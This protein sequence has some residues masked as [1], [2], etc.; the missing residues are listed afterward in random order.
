MNSTKTLKLF[1]LFLLLNF[2]N[3][4]LSQETNVQILPK[5]IPN[6]PNASSLGKYG[7]IPVNLSTG[8]INYNIPLLEIEEGN[9]K[10][11]ISLNYNYSGLIVDEDPGIAGYGWNLTNNF[12]ITR[13][14]KGRPDD[15]PLGYFGNNFGNVYVKPYFNNILPF[16]NECDLTFASAKGRWDSE[17][18]LFIINTP[19]FSTSFF[20]NT[21]KEPIFLK[22]ENYK[23][24][25]IGN[26]FFNGFV[27]ID[28]N[29]NEYVFDLLETST[30]SPGFDGEMSNYT[31]AWHL[32]KLTLFNTKQPITFEYGGVPYQKET[33]TDIIKRPD[34]KTMTGYCN[35]TG[36]LGM[37]PHDESYTQT[38]EIDIDV[39][40]LAKIVFSKGEILFDNDVDNFVIKS[41]QLNDKKG[42]LIEKYNFNFYKVNNIIGKFINSIDK[43]NK[44]TDLYQRMYSFEYYNPFV[45]KFNYKMQDYWGYY[46]GISTASLADISENR[47]SGFNTS[48]YGA[49]KKITYP[50]TGY[51]TIEYEP[52]IIAVGT[53]FDFPGNYI[54]NTQ[55]YYSLDASRDGDTATLNQSLNLKGIVKVEANASASGNNYIQQAD[56]SF[57]HTALYNS[58]LNNDCNVN[59]N[60]VV[61]SASDYNE[62]SFINQP[63]VSKSCYFNLGEA[64]ANINLS[65][66]RS[67][68]S[69]IA[70]ASIKI[71]S[72]PDLL[73]GGIRV[74]KT[75]ECS[76]SGNCIS[77]EYKYINEQGLSSGFLLD[78]PL[79]TY[80]TTWRYQYGG[81]T[82]CD[83][84]IRNT[85]SSSKIPL[86]SFQGS[87]V[88][89]NRVETLINDGTNGKT[90]SYYD[91]KKN[92][93]NNK[94]G[95][96]NNNKDWRKG[97]LI[98]QEYYKF[99]NGSFILDNSIENTFEVYKPFTQQEALINNKIGMSFKGYFKNEI[100]RQANIPVENCNKVN[101]NNNCYQDDEL[102]EPEFYL[103]TKTIKKN[104]KVF[105]VVTEE[106]RYDYNKLTGK[107][108]NEKSSTSTEET[109]ETKYAYPQDLQNEP[110]ANALIAKNMIG[111]PL[112]TET[113]RN[114][115][116]LSEQKTE[117]ANDASTSNLLLPKYIYAKKGTGDI[118]KITDKKITYDQYDDKGNIL[119]YTPESGSPVALI[120]GYN[121]TQPIAK[122][123]N[124]T[125]A[126]AIAK[127]TTDENI[128][129][130]NLPKA[131]VT[132]YTYIPL[133]GVKSITDPK[134]QT[135]TYEY[136][137]FNRLKF[138]KDQDLNILQRYCYN[139]KGQI[140]DCS[141]V[142]QITYISS[143]KIGSFIKNNCATGG[144]G[145]PLT[146][147]EAAG[148]YSSTISQADADSKGLMKFNTDGQTYANTNGTCTFTSSTQSGLF[149]KNNCVT[150][151]VGSSV[152]YNVVAGAYTSTI[153]QVD[154]DA[155][156]QANV[157][158]NGQT[159]A[160]ANGT[161]TFK[162]IVKSGSFKSKNCATNEIALPVTYTVAAGTYTSIISQADADAKAQADVTVNGPTYADDVGKCKPKP[163]GIQK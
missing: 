95:I 38:T 70:K 115:E 129:R 21:N 158:A 134:G 155:K 6:S 91:G 92:F 20:L 1:C 60:L 82:P 120:W 67:Q 154:A 57:V 27:L 43:Y 102:Y 2:Q 72:N 58:C 74:K 112:K 128:F 87:P 132:T 97:N 40:V 118:S 139:Y 143:A 18:D 141:Q 47:K 42:D 86:I 19:T 31:S 65:V 113:F 109:L 76:E 127:Y 25:I 24:E 46:N 7:D 71:L 30:I 79:F 150:G 29:G 149:I 4:I 145:L 34:I 78:K 122:I 110:F 10:I 64:T 28:D 114:T 105:G 80:D 66:E 136:D 125:Y 96:Y 5:I 117:Y 147:S 22:G 69:G 32:R 137:Q 157:T 119:Q 163:G 104:N 85:L 81:N 161:C 45:G 59:N 152:T 41:I 50:T 61:I 75:I 133:V 15:G 8:K 37:I 89:Y 146:Y 63:S 17:P 33:H 121:Q 56:A 11:P 48:L 35:T 90:V 100:A 88:L 151:S 159:Y 39:R 130:N 99:L 68:N 153:S 116:K 51:T 14:V 12:S 3:S 49:L 101:L 77:K 126:E 162:S 52:Q 94:T 13:I 98:K 124:A 108:I 107:L 138:I 84:I 123:E 106:T 160:N 142:G 55:N 73:I 54:F 53:N 44:T 23:L 140:I 26:T 83:I 9:Y 148:A 131:M 93:N 36:G 111:N 135:T 144:V 156:A 62:A 103:L 16:Q